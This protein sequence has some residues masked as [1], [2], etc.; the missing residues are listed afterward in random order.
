MP[1][2]EQLEDGKK[3]YEAYIHECEII[4]KGGG[5]PGAIEQGISWT[6]QCHRR[7]HPDAGACHEAVEYI[8]RV[9]TDEIVDALKMVE[10]QKH[11]LVRHGFDVEEVN[12][13]TVDARA[14]ALE[15]LRREKYPIKEY[16]SLAEMNEVAK[17]E[18]RKL[19]IDDTGRK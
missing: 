19:V 17:G 11:A 5:H 18:G 16:S 13:L 12:R 2:L 4:L 10:D 1:T 9:S 15:M 14:V 3:S 7:K 8:G 6:T